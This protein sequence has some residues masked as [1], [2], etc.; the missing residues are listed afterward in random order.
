M[1]CDESYRYNQRMMTRIRKA[2]CN[3]PKVF[4]LTDKELRDEILYE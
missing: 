3:T 2:T 1:E 4:I